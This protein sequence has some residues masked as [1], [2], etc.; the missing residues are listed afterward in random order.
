VPLASLAAD[1]PGA[2]TLD[3]VDPF[4]NEWTVNGRQAQAQSN[5]PIVYVIVYDTLYVRREVSGCNDATP[6][7]AAHDLSS[8]PCL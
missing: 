7:I 3:M 6:Y 5:A 1:D 4:I 2:S 8:F